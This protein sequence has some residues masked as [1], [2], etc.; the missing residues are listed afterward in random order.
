M[1]TVGRLAVSCSI[2]LIFEGWLSSGYQSWMVRAHTPYQVGK[3]GR[4]PSSLPSFYLRLTPVH[5]M[6]R[7]P[8]PVGLN[9]LEPRTECTS[10]PTG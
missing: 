5:E 8:F 1:L 9:Y 6:S 10:S 2:V 7:S 3:E 4:D